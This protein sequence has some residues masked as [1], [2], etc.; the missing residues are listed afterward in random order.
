MKKKSQSSDFKW[1]VD[2]DFQVYVAPDR[3]YPESRTVSK[4]FRV[5]VRRK[6]ITTWG[7]D[8]KEINTIVY[9]SSEKVGDILYKTQAE[10]EQ[11]LPAVYKMLRERYG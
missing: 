7:L 6:G 3:V 11:S 1:C 8:E 9:T 4:Q 2:N 5:V 10:A